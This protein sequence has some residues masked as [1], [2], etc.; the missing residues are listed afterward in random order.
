MAIVS[1]LSNQRTI[2]DSRYKTAG[3]LSFVN[4]FLTLPMTIAATLALGKGVAGLWIFVLMP[5][6]A[7][8]CIFT[9]YSL[10][11]FK[12]LLN[13]KYDIHNISNLINVLIVCSIIII[14]K[15]LIT[16]VLMITV[17]GPGA[18]GLLD[19]IIGLPCFMLAGVVGLIFGLRLLSIN[20]ETSV[21]I[22]TY[23]IIC[24]ISSALM[25]SV[26]LILV[27]LLLSLPNNIILGI[28]FFKEAETEPQVEFV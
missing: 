21:L 10:L 6:A 5:L 26:I 23:A 12:R 4:A 9:I 24:L 14:V 28:L 17:K 8:A 20:Y 25:V 7:I 22:R 18:V 11:Q 15:N 13:E 2:Q 27:G 1:N 3:Y 19:G 16:A